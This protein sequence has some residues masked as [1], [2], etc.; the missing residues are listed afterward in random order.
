MGGL[1]Q[2]MAIKRLIYRHKDQCLDNTI[3][4][5]KGDPY[6]YGKWFMIKIA[7]QDSGERMVFSINAVEVVGCP[8]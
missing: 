6:V 8:Y 4:S 3:N 2:Y 7:L 5:K 1:L